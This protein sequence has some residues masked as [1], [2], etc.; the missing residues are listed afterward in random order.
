MERVGASRNLLSMPRRRAPL[1]TARAVKSQNAILFATTDSGIGGAISAS[2]LKGPVRQLASYFCLPIGQKPKQQAVA[3][4]AAMVLWPLIA[5]LKN[6]EGHYDRLVARN[7]IVACNSASVRKPE[8]IKLI[9][10]FCQ[11]VEDRP[12]DFDLPSDMRGRLRDLNARLAENEKLSCP[13]T[14]TKL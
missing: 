8:A 9:A 13:N 4:T 5:P 6:N 14:S 1:P 3:Y 2:R 12:D 7:V 10:Q 11:A